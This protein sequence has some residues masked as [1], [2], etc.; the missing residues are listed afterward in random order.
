MGFGMRK[1]V[2]TRKPKQPFVKLRKLYEIELSHKKRGLKDNSEKFT[3][4][5]IEEV[6]SKIRKRIRS[7]T[8]KR[9]LLFSLI[10]LAC[11]LFLYFFVKKS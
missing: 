4:A 6:K 2:Y 8:I 9:R 3:K 7:E 1:E 10:V 11:F 5:Q